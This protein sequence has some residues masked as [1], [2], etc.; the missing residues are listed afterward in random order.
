[1]TTTTNYL[2]FIGAAFV[3][4]ISPGPNMIYLLSRSLCQGRAAGILSWLGVVLGL[5]GHMVCAAAGL[6]ALFLAVP[7]AYELMKFAGAIYLLWMAW[8][9]VR[10]G[11]RSPFE[12]Q[13][14]PAES[15][16]RLFTMGILT[17]VLNP[18]IAIFYLSVLPQFITPD[19]GSVFTQSLILGISQI[20]VGST[21]N[22]M[23]VLSAAGLASWFS[24]N[25]FWLTVQRY[26]MGIVLGALAVKLLTQQRTAA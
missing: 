22:M 20:I 6:T 16:R 7:L 3:M 10:P 25:R 8:K 11:S 21:I 15:R 19:T 14:L 24:K 17:S 2:I 1:M 26:F 5:V 18:K 23:V 12:A 13:E 9:A 4:A